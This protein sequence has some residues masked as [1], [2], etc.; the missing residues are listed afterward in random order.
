MFI[1]IGESILLHPNILASESESSTYFL[2]DIRMPFLD[3]ITS[4][5]KKYLTYL[6]SLVWKCLCKYFFRLSIPFISFPVITISSTY[7]TSMI[8]FPCCI[9]Q[10]REW[11][12]CLTET[13]LLSHWCKTPRSGS[14]KLFQTVKWLLQPTKFRTLS[15]SDKAWW[16]LHVNFFIRILLRK[17]FLISDWWSGQ[18]YVAAN[19]TKIRTDVI[20][21]TEEKVSI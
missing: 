19:D 6:R 14:Q 8:L 20:F 18:W 15:L 21:V 17:T 12:L 16:L 11:P 9:R 13:K 10:N 7:T 3:Q 2:C 1:F 5:P 4:M